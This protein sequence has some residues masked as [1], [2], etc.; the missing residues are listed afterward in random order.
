MLK[1]VLRIDVDIH[2][3]IAQ[4]PLNTLKHVKVHFK[5]TTTTRFQNENQKNEP[6]RHYSDIDLDKLFF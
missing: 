2:F 1:P 5:K 4:S 3:L 6:Y